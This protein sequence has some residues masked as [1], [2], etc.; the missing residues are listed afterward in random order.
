MVGMS[1]ALQLSRR[2]RGFCMRKFALFAASVAFLA[3][4]GAA[5][6][7][8]SLVY[9][10]SWEVMDGPFWED[11]PLADTGQEAAALLFGG[12][13]ADYSI[14]TVGTD[15][16]AVNYKAWY[17]VIGDFG[18]NNGGFEFAQDYVST[19]SSQAPGYYYSGN[20]YP[21]GVST[22]AASAYVRDSAFAGNIN[23]AFRT[24]SNGVPE[25]LTLS[26]FGAG[27]L[28]TV[29]MRRRKRA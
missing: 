2:L 5:P 1:I 24:V 4:A 12:S 26:L 19:N 18:P 21:G 13:A 3:F 25:P 22:D 15:P 14:S 7:F 17:A 29:V 16:S 10:G 9:V 28:G 6:A 11:E 27:L 23:Y 8:A 20:N